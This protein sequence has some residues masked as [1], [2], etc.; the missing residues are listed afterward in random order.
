LHLKTCILID[1]DPDDQEI[2]QIAI[3]ENNDNISCM[4]FNNAIDALD[5]LRSTIIYP[6]VIFVDLNMPRMSG[7]QCLVELRKIDQINTVPVVVCS[8]SSDRRF[9]EEALNNG[10][11][12]YIIKPASISELGGILKEI[13]VKLK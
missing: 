7:L 5:Y 6:D 4:V 12:K 1:D 2:F 3:N 10:A 13:F 11:A 8:T 9:S